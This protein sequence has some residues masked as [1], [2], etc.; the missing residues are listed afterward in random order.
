ME[1]YIKAT[2]VTVKLIE[3]VV[4]V[5]MVIYAIVWLE[6]IQRPW[7]EPSV[8]SATRSDLTGV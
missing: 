8:T 6:R 7:Q 3:T 2:E 4:I 1:K 5:S